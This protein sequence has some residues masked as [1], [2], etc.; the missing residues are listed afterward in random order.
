MDYRIEVYDTWGRRL[1]SFD[2][3]PLFEAV[4]TMPDQTDRIRGTLP[5][6]LGELGPACRIRVIVAEQPFCDAYV[7]E[8]SPRWSDTR[9]LILDRYVNFHELIEVD[10]ERPARDGNTT[11]SRGYVN[12]EIGSI[13]KSAIN[14]ALGPVHYLVD[15]GAYPD[16]AQREYTKFEARKTA[17]NELEVGG[18][19]SGQWVGGARIDASGAYA[20]DG[21]T[22]AGLVVDGGV[23][24]DLRFLMIDCEETGLN[25]HARSR[26]P[27]VADWTSAE[28][29]ASGYK[30]TGEAAK[31]ALQDLLDTKG[32][33]FIEL[34]PHRDS[35]G[36]FDDRIDVYGRYLG[37]VYGGVS[38]T[39]ECFNAAM[40]EKGLADVYL[41][42]DG[43]Y[44]VPELEL[45]DFFSYAAENSDSVEATGQSLTS[46][47]VSA[48]GFEA[49]STLA[50]AAG[51]FVWSVD[52]DLAI[53]FRK[54]ER[55]DRVCFFNPLEM[56]V[57]LGS[58]LGDMG[59]AVYFHGN[60]ITG[61]VAKTYTRGASIDEYGY[62]ARSLDHFGISLEEDADK[63]VEGLLDDLAYPQPTGAVVFWHGNSEVR[64]GDLV[65]MR[66]EGLRRLEREIDGEWGDRFAGKLVARVREVSHRFSGRQ[67]QTR[68]KF[69]SPLRSVE[70]PM[71]FMVRSQPGKSTLFQFRL[72]ESAVGLDLGYHLD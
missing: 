63:L 9:K 70:R 6:T 38:G 54:A 33:D 23:W 44:H 12:R 13:V 58:G 14:S 66:G 2:E 59:N 34:N 57:A 25:S 53:R 36:A 29:D 26:H 61:T 24:P 15:H 28:Y 18:I 32:I 19:S 1:A 3:V 67:V 72:D 55:P 8:V 20:K 43:R 69:T 11:V 47:D 65:E 21:D 27:E 51:G 40:V 60:P 48:G 50:Y 22:I 71:G 37:V 39:G 45:K 62:E 17:G 16:G 31:A 5:T 68:V 42:Q 52:V 46:F 64:V 4:R 56:G 10:A 7:T 30:L 35:S 41:Y 49:L